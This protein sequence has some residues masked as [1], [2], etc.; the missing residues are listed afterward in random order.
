MYAT[1]GS[2]EHFHQ[3]IIRVGGGSGGKGGFQLVGSK[4]AHATLDA[5]VEFYRKQAY[6]A[7][8]GKRDV[9]AKLILP[10]DDL[11]E[12]A[13]PFWRT[14]EEATYDTLAA[15]DTAA[16]TADGSVGTTAALYGSPDQKLFA[17]RV[18]PEDGI[19]D[20]CS[21]YSIEGELGT[22]AVPTFEE[23]MRAAARHCGDDKE[24]VAPGGDCFKKAALYGETHPHNG[25]CLREGYGALNSDEIAAMHMYTMETMF[26]KILNGQLGCY[27][28]T[29]T[30][31]PDF[32]P[33]T[34]LLMSALA[35][36]PQCSLTLY[37]GMGGVSADDV[38]EPLQQGGT[39]TNYIMWNSFVSCTDSLDTVREFVGKTGERLVFRIVASGA[40]S[41]A[42]YS[43]IP[44]EKEYLLPPM[45]KAEVVSIKRFGATTEVQIRQILEPQDQKASAC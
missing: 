43:A 29:Q 32:L 14:E 21:T 36:L 34:K 2:S 35:K 25:K 23:A 44:G 24:R 18:A 4:H 8:E 45:T 22:T 40:A 31:I 15:A 26:F 3:Q 37:R 13:V 16:D 9:P 39:V 5:L 41:I 42:A 10:S 1:A 20:V 38:V 17:D 33:F 28:Q 12:Y 11:A 27:G 30:E 19:Y 7:E 6:F